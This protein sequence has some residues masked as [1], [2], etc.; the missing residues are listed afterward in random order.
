MK[1]K[2]KAHKVKAYYQPFGSQPM[3]WRIV[4]PRVIGWIQLHVYDM[5]NVAR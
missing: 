1:M 2:D 3:W 5:T 4:N